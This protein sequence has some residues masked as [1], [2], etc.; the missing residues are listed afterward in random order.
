M[1]KHQICNF[2]FDSLHT[3][4]FDGLQ[5]LRETSN[6]K[7]E[8][9]KKFLECNFRMGLFYGKMPNQHIYIRPLFRQPFGEALAPQGDLESQN[10]IQYIILRILFQEGAILCK[11]AKLAYLYLTPPLQP[12]HLGRPQHL[13]VTSDQKKT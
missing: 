13:R 6:Q 9:Y 10:G 7:I 8:N 12:A 3:S 5:H 11:N 1:Q 2:A 4:P